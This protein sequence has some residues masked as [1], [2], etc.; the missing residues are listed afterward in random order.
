MRP[1]SADHP[2]ELTMKNLFAPPPD[3]NMIQKISWYGGL[4]IAIFGTVVVVLVIIKVGLIA[5]DWVF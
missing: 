4:A 3:Y 1:G 2:E 5:L